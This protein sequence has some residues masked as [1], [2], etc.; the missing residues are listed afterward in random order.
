MR[1][2]IPFDFA[3]LGPVEFAWLLLV[4]GG[5][6]LLAPEGR[7]ILAAAVVGSVMALFSVVR[8]FVDETSSA[9]TWYVGPILVAPLLGA[10]VVLLGLA[11]PWLVA[12]VGARPLVRA[13]V[14]AVVLLSLDG[15]RSPPDIAMLRVISQRPRP[16]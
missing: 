2:L 14:A 13:W 11:R 15:V 12:Q 9:W 8:F 4:F 1:N 10:G 5:L 7:R 16:R 3:D 6:S